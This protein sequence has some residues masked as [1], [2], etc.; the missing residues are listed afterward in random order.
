M[1]IETKTKPPTV[2]K[3][4]NLAWL[5]TRHEFIKHSEKRG[6]HINKE[7]FEIYREFG[8]IEPVFQY[9]NE[10]IYD[11]AQTYL[12]WNIEHMRLKSLTLP[13]FVK[14]RKKLIEPVD[15]LTLVSGDFNANTLR[16]AKKEFMS[17]LDL[18]MWIRYYYAPAVEYAY[19]TKWDYYR[20]VEVLNPTPLYKQ[21]QRLKKQYDKDHVPVGLRKDRESTNAWLQTPEQW[22]KERK[23][24]AQNHAAEVL[25]TSGLSAQQVERWIIN[26]HFNGS[27]MDPI[28]GQTWR[29]FITN[30]RKSNWRRLESFKGYALLAQDFYDYAGVLYLF[31]KDAAPE[32]RLIPP[33]DIRDALFGSWKKRECWNCGEEFEQVNSG[34]RFCKSCKKQVA[35][36][37]KMPAKF[38]C[39]AKNCGQSLLR[40]QD[41][42]GFFSNFIP[43]HRAHKV[44]DPQTGET[45]RG[46]V[47]LD[48]SLEYGS[49]V[50]RVQCSKCGH[51]NNL[52]IE[53]GWYS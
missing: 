26:F 27:E 18:L 6:L 10:E 52:K 34:E 42:S 37:E 31:L 40:F 38:V 43:W 19:R 7:V 16:N 46:E 22:D 5:L 21:M 15:W 30:I 48:V 28:G 53:S 1:E 8:F 35:W 51:V 36:N 24:F 23:D 25:K 29:N 17:I 41:G 49:L 44:T 45:L 50:V 33:S 3:D 13:W 9:E 2:H 39:E 32:H 12:L 20:K 14:S 47:L 11:Q 4:R